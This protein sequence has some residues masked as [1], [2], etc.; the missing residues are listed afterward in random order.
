MKSMTKEWLNLAK[1]DLDACK[2][3][4]H[5][6]HLTNVVSFHAQQAV[7][8]TLKAVIEEYHTVLVKTHNLESLYECVKSYGVVISDVDLLGKLDNLYID[9]RYPSDTGLLPYGKPTVE[10]AQEF[11]SFAEKTHRQV[12]AILME[13]T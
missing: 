13:R 5:I 3:L 4:L 8:K 7:E 11:Y 12:K 1:D 6:K 9:S 2:Q 10:D